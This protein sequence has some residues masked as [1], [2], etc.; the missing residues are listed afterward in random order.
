MLNW[1]QVWHRV[2]LNP[3]FKGMQESDFR[4]MVF[5]QIF[6]PAPGGAATANQPQSFAGGAI[7]LGIAAS[8]YVPSG[9]ASAQAGRN[10]QLFAIDFAYSNNEAITPGGPIL[11][12]AL[13]GGG[14]SNIFPSRELLIAPNQQI[15]CRVANVTT[16]SLTVHVAFHTMVYRYTS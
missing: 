13:L 9:A 8:A 7:I 3:A 4:P 6:T 1:T 14:E 16:G 12:D 11:A 10:R 2:R 15:T 5:N